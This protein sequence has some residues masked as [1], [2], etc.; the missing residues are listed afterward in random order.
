ME[1]LECAVQSIITILFVFSMSGYFGRFNKYLELTS[2]FK[3]QYLLASAFC[4]L[5]CL[6]LRDWRG[7]A[8]ALL[9]A[10]INFSSIIT[11]YRAG[12]S[13][14]NRGVKGRH[15]KL[16]FANIYRLN[17]AHDTFIAFVDRHTPDIIIVQEVDAVW[18]EALQTLHHQYPFFEALPRGGGSGIALYSRFPFE[19]L[20]IVSTEGEAR[21]GILASLKVGNVTVYMLSI[22]PRAPLRSEHFERRNKMLSAAAVCLRDLP[23]PKICIGDL[24]TSLWSPYYRSFAKQSKLVNVRKGFGLLP[25][26]PTFMVFKWLMIPIDHCLVSPDIRIVN[27]QA[28]EQIGSDH[29]PL[30][31]EMEIG[32][33]ERVSGRAGERE[34]NFQYPLSVF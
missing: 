9:I 31:V 15:L 2:H 3:I 21:P 8:G 14:V 23:S 17:T 7:A 6:I 12:Q 4:L 29:L 25:S 34:N 10:G 22:H 33:E 20:P 13:T 28:G 32:E 5:V 11:W 16:I 30:I 27:A 19:R 1:N 24:N 26:W 18:A